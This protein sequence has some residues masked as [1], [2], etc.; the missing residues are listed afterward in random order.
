MCCLDKQYTVF[1][2]F[3]ISIESSSV[4]ISKENFNFK[5]V[6]MNRLHYYMVWSHP[7][8]IVGYNLIDEKHI[9]FLLQNT[10]LIRSLLHLSIQLT[11]NSFLFKNVIWCTFID[12]FNKCLESQCNSSSFSWSIH[13][14]LACLHFVW[15]VL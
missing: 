1:R 2:V 3:A 13:L 11:L 8:M 7:D 6:S 14:R 4:H 10:T 15:I 5:F 12:L 9:I